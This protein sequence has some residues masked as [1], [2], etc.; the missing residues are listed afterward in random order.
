MGLLL[1]GVEHCQLLGEEIPL[2]ERRHCAVAGNRATKPFCDG[3]TRQE[4]FW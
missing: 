4:L 1:T 3:S 2:E